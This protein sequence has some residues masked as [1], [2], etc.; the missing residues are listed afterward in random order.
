MCD[1][2]QNPEAPHDRVIA[3][4]PLQYMQREF[5]EGPKFQLFCGHKLVIVRHGAHYLHKI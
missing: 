1:T 4:H 2:A 3:S 5:L